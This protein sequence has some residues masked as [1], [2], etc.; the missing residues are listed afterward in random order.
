MEP[1]PPDALPAA[2][3]DAVFGLSWQYTER[4]L[5]TVGVIAGKSEPFRGDLGRMYSKVRLP[6]RF[7][8]ADYYALFFNHAGE[9]LRIACVGNSLKDDPDGEAAR[10]RYEEL[11]EIV[12]RKIPIV[13]VYEDEG[14]AWSRTSDWWASLHDGKVH[15]ATGFRGEVMEAVLEIR[16]ESA[17]AGSYSLIVDHLPRMQ[18]L[19]RAAD[20]DEKSAF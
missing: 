5:L 7:E 8:D 19:N 4:E 11:K 6:R 15:W 17:I 13:G 1:L 10:K 12:S 20:H 3:D 18:A 16:A 9:L 14:G 2:A